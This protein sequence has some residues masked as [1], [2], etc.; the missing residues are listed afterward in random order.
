MEALLRGLQ[1]SLYMANRLKVYM[2]YLRDLPITQTRMNFETELIEFY[3]HILCFLAR[4]IQIYQKNTLTRA[5]DAFWKSKEVHDF[6]DECFNIGCRADMEARNCDHALNVYQREE[7]NQC[8]EHLQ[9]ELMELKALQEKGLEKLQESAGFKYD[10][11]FSFAS[12][13]REYVRQVK[14]ELF[15]AEFSVFF[16]EEE[17]VELWGSFLNEKLDNIYRKESRFC[18]IFISAEYAKKMWTNHERRSAQA[19]ALSDRNDYLLP[20][21][22]DDTEIEGLPPTIAYID[23]RSLTPETFA[24]LIIKKIRSYKHIRSRIALQQEE[25]N[26]RHEHLQR[27]SKEL[28]ARQEKGLKK[29]QESAGMR[30]NKIDLPYVEAAAFDSHVDELDARCHP[31]TREDLLH[32]IREWAQDP[33]GKCIFWLNG[34]AGTGKSTISRTVAQSFAEDGQLGA[35]FF[36]KRGEG[37]RGNASRFFT[38][39]TLH[40]VR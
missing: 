37:E 21:R 36:F 30:E 32:R 2:D 7:A 9:R 35:S 38:T 29:L 22:F 12:E 28:S 8:H 11:C 33:Q 10:V 26:Q 24:T 3:A 18:V 34:M 40:L 13:Q 6:E 17:Q 20:A 15:K 31:G 27:E 25:A 5:F 23:L 39:I 1:I 4:A 16:D 14:D 19:R